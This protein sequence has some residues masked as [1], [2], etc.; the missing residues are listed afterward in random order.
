M[1]YLR[2]MYLHSRYKLNLI[3]LESALL[4]SKLKETI[5]YLI[6]KKLI[7]KNAS[8]DRL[9]NACLKKFKGLNNRLAQEKEIKV[10]I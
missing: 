8:G 5:S 3:R 1:Q 2:T 6:L 7:R 10:Q 4:N 9:L